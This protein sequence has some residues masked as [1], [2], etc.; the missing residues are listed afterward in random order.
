VQRDPDNSKFRAI[1]KTTLG[2]QRSVEGA[3][4]AE[5]LLRAMNFYPKGPNTLVLERSQVDPALLFLGVSALEQAK[6]S[7]E[8]KDRKRKL[9][10]AKEVEEIRLSGD[11]SQAEAIRRADFMSKCPTEPD[12]GRGALLQVVIADDSVRRRFDGDD[13]V[14]DVLNWLGGH[15]SIIPEK[16]LS[17]EWCLVDLNRYPLVPIDCEKSLGKTLQ[18][19][20]CW[21][22]GR[23]EI[24]PSGDEWRLN[25]SV[26]NLIQGST[27]GLGAM[28]LSF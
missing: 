14:R 19:V 27:R 15:G 12:E 17:R 20:G 24:Q 18:H 8:Y 7:S 2:Y 9:R 11:S 3:P 16:I 28:D 23:L 21:P 13:V 4:G 26:G 5:S 1:D 6:D 25:G 22:S 10:F